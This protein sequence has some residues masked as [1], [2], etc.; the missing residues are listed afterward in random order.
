MS[1]LLLEDE[2]ATAAFAARLTGLLEPGDVIGLEGDLGA[3]KTTLAR[4]A[5]HALGVPE[6]VAVT[7]P[8]FALIHQYEGR[9]PIIHTDFYRLGGEETLIDLGVDELLA[10]GAVAFVEWG[11]KFTDFSNTVTLWLDLAIESEV[12]RRLRIRPGTARGEVL[13]AAVDGLW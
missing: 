10:G 9:L 3:G 8:T 4:A 2:H 7:S 13:V 1:E 5:I 12:A 11:R 6:E